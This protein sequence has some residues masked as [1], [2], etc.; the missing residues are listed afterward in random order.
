ME[1]I[2][3]TYTEQADGE[4]ISDPGQYEGTIKS[5]K[6]EDNGGGKHI[7]KV[8]LETEDGKLFL[9]RIYITDGK[10]WGLSKLVKAAQIGDVADGQ[11]VGFN[12]KMVVGAQVGFKLANK[13]NKA[14]TKE[15]LNVV[16]YTK[17]SDGIEL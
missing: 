1:N 10:S 4:F 3:F 8:L 7:L 2:E 17:P 15:F 12:A 13:W 6:L 16:A 11:K 14:K 5:A 9:D